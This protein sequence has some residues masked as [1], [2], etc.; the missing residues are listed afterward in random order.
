MIT[1]MDFHAQKS[2]KSTKVSTPFIHLAICLACNKII[3][4][5][6]KIAGRS[7]KVGNKSNPSMTFTYI[8]KQ[9]T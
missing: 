7:R 6:V 8:T 5:L 3:R 9:V 4:L 2:A 1:T